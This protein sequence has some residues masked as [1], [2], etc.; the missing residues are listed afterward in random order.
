MKHPTHFIGIGGIGMS[1]LARLL[2]AK[3]ETVSGSDIR[4]SEILRDL[5]M[6]GAQIY[7]GHDEKNIP[8]KARVVVSTDI[9]ATNPELKAALNPI[10]RSDLLQ[11]LMTGHKALLVAGTHGKTTTSSLLAH[12]LDSAGLSP[13]FVI[14][15]ILKNFE[16]NSALGSG[17]FFVA[18]ADESDGTHVKY[19]P[20]GLIVTNIDNDHLNHYGSE[21]KLIEAFKA[22]IYKVSN[23]DLLFTCGDDPL[24]KQLKLP[25]NHY[26]FDPSNNIQ[27]TYLN[28]RGL[29]QTFDLKINGKE[30][31][32]IYLPLIGRHNVLNAAAVFALSIKIGVSETAIRKAFFDFKGVKRRAD[33]KW[34]RQEV[35]VYDDYAHHP[36]E[37]KATLKA[38]ELAFPERRLVVV[39]QPHRYSRTKDCFH[40]FKEALNADVVIVTDLYAAGEAPIEG[41]STETLLKTLGNRALYIPRANLAQKL[42]ELIRPFD[43]LVT[44]GAGDITKLSDEL[45]SYPIRTLKMGLLFGGRS[46]E[47]EISFK[48]AKNI[49]QAVDRNLFEIHPFAISRQ[50]GWVMGEAAR[51]LLEEGS[52]FDTISDHIDE[53]CLEAVQ[54]CDLVFPC[55]HGTNGEDGTVQGFMQILRVGYVGCS[56]ESSAVAMN[57]ALTKRLCAYENIPMVPFVDFIRY[58]WNLEPEKWIQKI[59]SALK[60]PLFVKPVHLGSTVGVSKV[61]NQ[62]ELVQAIEH[63][64]TMDTHLII[65]EGIQAR[66]IEFSVLGAGPWQIFNPGEI[67]SSGEV[68]DYAAKYGTNSF[69][70]LDQAPLTKEQ[71]MEGKKIALDAY[72]A[73][74]ADGMARVDLFLT[75]EGKFLLNEINP[76]P[77]FTQKSLFPRMCEAGGLSYKDLIS[78]LAEEGLSN[79]L[80]RDR[81]H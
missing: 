45:L 72:K 65:E 4:E 51:T 25:G 74:R 21:E 28:Q 40:Q 81:I 68:Y 16:A 69:K 54:K 7:V 55:L 80:K 75:Q 12:T 47:H 29:T 6:K 60:Y 49:Y 34:E 58:E 20:Y 44:M 13:S 66:E 48:S 37:I 39:F 9:K 53:G 26:G 32:E 8:E 42:S 62:E 5:K 71:K 1:G 52:S 79:E 30:F 2:L 73:I 18:E 22:L 17:E 77:G 70:V 36:E 24:L 41:I 14:G 64:F 59:E 38:F 78:K 67:V 46:K 57:K 76:I 63:A 10:H 56:V 15:G 3:N 35:K 31:K 33:L 11:E 27:I 43:V 50:G 23:Y 61:K 19:Q